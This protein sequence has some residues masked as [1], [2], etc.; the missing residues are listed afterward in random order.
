MPYQKHPL[1]GDPSSVNG[2]VV[3]LSRSGIVG[4]LASFNDHVAHL[5]FSFP[6][7]KLLHYFPIPEPDTSTSSRFKLLRSSSDELGFKHRE[8][9]LFEE[10]KNGGLFS[11]GTSLIWNLALEEGDKILGLGEKTGPIN[12]IGFRYTHW[13]TDFF[14]YGID[15]DPLYASIPFFIWIREGRT[16]GML[17]DN[18]AK[19]IFDL[20]SSVKDRMS[21]E[22]SSGGISCWIFFGQHIH[23]ILYR[24]HQ[25]TGF[26]FST[27]IWSLGLHQSRYGYSS[28]KQIDHIASGFDAF[29]IPI[30]VIHLDIHYMDSFKVFTF[31]KGTFPSPEQLIKKHAEKGIRLVPIV[32]PGI[33]IEQGYPP[34]ESLH[35]N[36]VLSYPNGNPF[37]AGV[38]PGQCIFPDFSHEEVRKKW[39]EWM[40]F[41]FEKGIEGIWIDMNEPAVWGK[42]IPNEIICENDFLGELDHEESHNLYG[43]Y[44]AMATKSAQDSYFGQGKRNWV[45]TRCA[46][47]GTHSYAA[48][49]TGDNTASE[50]HML[51]GIRL[52][53]GLSM[54]GYS[55]CGMDIGGFVGEPSPALM[56]RWLSIGI[57]TPF[58]RIH[59]MIDSKSREPW[60]LGENSLDII[61]NY[62]NLRYQLAPYLFT[63][64]EQYA[65]EAKPIMRPMAFDYPYDDL[66]YENKFQHQFFFGE[67]LMLA[68]CTSRQDFV[69]V[70]FPSR[71]YYCFFTD[72]IHE[73]NT[74]SY[75]KAPLH[76]LPVFVPESGF[77][78]MQSRGSKL[79]AWHGNT[80]EVH[81][82]VGKIKSRY[83]QILNDG[84]QKPHHETEAL[85]EFVFDPEINQ[86]RLHVSRGTDYKIPYQKLLF[87]LHGG[88]EFSPSN[89]SN[90]EQAEIQMMPDLPIRD[91]YQPY[92]KGYNKMKVWKR[93]FDFIDQDIVF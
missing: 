62:L 18:P 47:A 73:A 32:D 88:N 93:E 12:K 87:I 80:L 40:K 69:E 3:E 29:D 89:E 26:G 35:K 10:Y 51:V 71:R 67:H 76:A 14:G 84:L 19:S 57:F 43:H 70:Y 8:H 7:Q 64:A 44:M 72:M 37:E 38:W 48:I 27:P 92:N 63:Y 75:V 28:Q 58:L 65:R 77:V 46:F 17:F 55:Y 86:I 59:S 31:D 52:L 13:N 78:A 24:Y 30:D 23:D 1:E 6:N 2:A 33:K 91:P 34:Y 79:F 90:W 82:Y 5:S 39:G 45:L 20:G 56:T 81:F 9:L 68:P 61:R 42:T 54:S 53:L 49:W 21:L 25:V 11:K 60:T 4:K 85:I 50:E 22:F 74:A 36:E 16:F 41:Y 83:V 15:S 66:V